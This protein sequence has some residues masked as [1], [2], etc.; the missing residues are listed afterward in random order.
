VLHGQSYTISKGER[1]AQMRLVEVPTAS[2]YKVESIE[3][4]GDDRGGGFGSS[5]VR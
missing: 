4:I 3:G 5:G 2:F 1:F